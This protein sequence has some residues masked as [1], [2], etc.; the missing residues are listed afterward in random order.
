MG[1][2]VATSSRY[3]SLQLNAEVILS[4]RLWYVSTMSGMTTSPYLSPSLTFIWSVCWSDRPTRNRISALPLSLASLPQLP[5]M[6][7][8]WG[9]PDMTSIHNRRGSGCQCTNGIIRGLGGARITLHPACS[10]YHR[11]RLLH[12]LNKWFVQN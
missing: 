5:R 1:H 2:S 12:S 3:L 8:R 6:N 11:E 9:H 4:V 10:P 7:F